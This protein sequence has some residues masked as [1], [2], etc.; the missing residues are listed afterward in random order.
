[1]FVPSTRIS[2]VIFTPS[3][4]SF[5][6]L[7]QRRSVDLPQPDGPMNAVTC[8]SGNCS[9]MSKSACFSPYQTLRSRMSISMAPV[10]TPG[11]ANVTS[12]FSRSRW[13]SPGGSAGAGREDSVIAMVLEGRRQILSPQA[14]ADHYRR[15]VEEQD[16]D[17]QQDGGGV[18]HRDGGFDVRTLEADVV[19]VKAQVHELALEVDEREIAV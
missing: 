5:I 11:V 12:V 4:R 2:P 3:M 8:F 15:Q 17:E 9:E 7:R 10:C 19:N 16:D 6:R 13:S 18:H 14:A 1:M